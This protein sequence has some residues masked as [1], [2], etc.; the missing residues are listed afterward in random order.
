MLT[1]EEYTQLSAEE[2]FPEHVA[3]PDVDSP[4]WVGYLLQTYEDIDMQRGWCRYFGP[5]TSTRYPGQPVEVVPPT[6]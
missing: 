1:S 5:R 4:E 3:V 6:S 2:K